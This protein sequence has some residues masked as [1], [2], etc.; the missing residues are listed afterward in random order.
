MWHYS[1]L[2]ILYSGTPS[3]HLYGVAILLVPLARAA[4]GN[5]LEPVSERILRIHLK[6]DLSFMIVVS[7]YAPT[8]LSNTTSEVVSASEA[9]YSQI[10]DTVSSVPPSDL[11]VILGDFNAHVGSNHSSRN[12]VTSPHGIGECNENGV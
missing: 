8:N 6:C 1:S 12:S 2:L 9:F 11:L 7:V 4:A 10:Q 5:V 3:S